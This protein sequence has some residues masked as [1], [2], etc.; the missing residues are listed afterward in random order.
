MASLNSR[1]S[2]GP[3]RSKASDPAAVAAGRATRTRNAKT[4]TD[5]LAPTRWAQR[6][7]APQVS[8]MTRTGLLWPTSASG[9]ENRA[10]LALLPAGRSLEVSR[11]AETGDR[12]GS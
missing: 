10:R 2:N 7:A 5:R 12:G 3:S 8:I 6:I 9:S 11:S 1:R 4:P